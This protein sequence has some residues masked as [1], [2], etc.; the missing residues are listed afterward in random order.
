MFLCS[1]V[2]SSVGLNLPLL[3]NTEETR[4]HLACLTLRGTVAPQLTQPVL[5]LRL[6][7][8]LPQL[9]GVEGLQLGTP[10]RHDLLQFAVLGV[11]KAAGPDGC[12]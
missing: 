2:S 5:G 7:R 10:S 1:S 4:S 12:F 6:G 3:A 11:V 9:D 8:E